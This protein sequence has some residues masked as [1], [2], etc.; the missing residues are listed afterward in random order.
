LIF[1]PFLATAHKVEVC[2]Q[3]RSP[4]YLILAGLC[5]F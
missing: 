4:T 3:K 5:P 2:T 1:F